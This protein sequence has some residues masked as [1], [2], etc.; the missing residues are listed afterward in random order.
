MTV[1][2]ILKHKGHDIVAARPTD[3]I[4]EICHLLTHRSIGAVVVTD[5]AEQ[6]LGIISERDIVQALASNGAHALEMTAGQLMTRALR[7]AT[8]HTTVG[9]AMA[10]MTAGRFRHLPV[11]E[12]D[13]MVGLISIGDVV[14]ARIMQQEA[15]VDT[16]RAY[17]AGAA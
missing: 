17:V 7:T 9:E 10:M 1:A 8:P 5:Q 14:K 2:A 6:L 13:V 3:T 11:I 12:R 4:A 16:L 15:E